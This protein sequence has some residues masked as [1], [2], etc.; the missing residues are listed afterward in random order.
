M[1]CMRFVLI[2]VVLV[3]A[4]FDN[5][6]I[7]AAGP[8]QGAE[9]AQVEGVKIEKNKASVLPGYRAHKK[10]D[11][12]LIMKEGSGTPI[13]E[14]ICSCRMTGVFCG[15]IVEPSTVRCETQTHP[16]SCRPDEPADQCTMSGV[17]HV[18]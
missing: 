13:T 8:E 10:G 2:G 1:N 14:V 6:H 15:V 18:P 5:W 4:L 9:Q 16:L 12:V 7:E 17:V 11:K 3:I